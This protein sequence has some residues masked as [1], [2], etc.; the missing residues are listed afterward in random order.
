[1]TISRPFNKRLEFLISLM[2]QNQPSE[3][4]RAILSSS[5]RDR[6]HHTVQDELHDLFLGNSEGCGLSP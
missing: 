5:N 1:M 2:Y 4:K 3:E 6:T